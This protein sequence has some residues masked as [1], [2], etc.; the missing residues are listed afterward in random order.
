MAD[1]TALQVFSDYVCPFCYMG[2]GLVEKLL[3]EDDLNLEVTWRPLQLQPDT[4]EQGIPLAAYF[5]MSPDEARHRLEELR[6]RMDELGRPFNPPTTMVNT[7]KAHLLAEYA[8]DHDKMDQVRSALF[9]AYWADGQDISDESVL[10]AIA[11][12]AGL[13]ADQA[14]ASVADGVHMQRLAEAIDAA[15]GYR[16][17]GVPA[18]VVDKQRQIS[19]AMPYPFLVE[20]IRHYSTTEGSSR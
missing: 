15:N 12:E 19:G 4:P 20:M 7:L 10:R 18:F 9:R 13:D 3:A 17:R 16:V 11:T 14:M 6:P 8:R 1:A 5:A 2:E